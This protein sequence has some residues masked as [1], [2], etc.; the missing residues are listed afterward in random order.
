MPRKQEIAKVAKEIKSI[1]EELNRTSSQQPSWT[2]NLFNYA[3]HQSDGNALGK[4]IAAQTTK[5]WLPVA[6]SFERFLGEFFYDLEFNYNPLDDGNSTSTRYL[7]AGCEVYIDGELKIIAQ[8]FGMDY[9]PYLSVFLKLPNGKLIKKE[10]VGRSPGEDW[11][12]AIKYSASWL[13]K[14][15]ANLEFEI[16]E[17]LES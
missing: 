12:K 7:N 4:E 13:K 10:L 17:A 11:S 8:M 3:R 14:E 15:I 6:K 5:A 1:K 2:S 16:E 9:A